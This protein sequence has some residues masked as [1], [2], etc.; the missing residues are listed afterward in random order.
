MVLISV[1]FGVIPVCLLGWVQRIGHHPRRE[2]MSGT[3]NMPKIFMFAF[4]DRKK[5]VV[6][7]SV[8]DSCADFLY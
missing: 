2:K 4:V 8:S 6:N 3:A 1:S 5:Q 7:F